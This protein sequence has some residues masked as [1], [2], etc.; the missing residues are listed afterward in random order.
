MTVAPE[1]EFD[2]FYESP[3]VHVLGGGPRPTDDRGSNGVVFLHGFTQNAHC[4]GRF[5][6]LLGAERPVR[7]VDLPGH[8]GHPGGSAHIDPFWA[9]AE[10]LAEATGPAAYVGYSMGG[11]IALH[12]ALAHPGSVDRLVLIGATAGIQDPEQRDRRRASDRVLAS[13]LEAIGLERFLDEWLA[14]PLF[15][16]LPR[17]A[18]FLEHRLENTVE[19]LAWSLRNM[20]TGVM[21]P[22][23]ER[24]AGITCPVLVIAGGDDERYTAL[25]SRLV[26]GIGDNARMEIVA[27]VGHSVHLEAPDETARI[28]SE[29]LGPNG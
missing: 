23:W 3:A 21:E 7:G 25:A 2:D 20:G 14:Q 19:G 10:R 9:T 8:R 12:L 4:A 27:D 17:S 26:T 24:L 15:A 13:R 6:D 22:L 16:R 11:R 18:A 1:V 29:F 28:V 5:L